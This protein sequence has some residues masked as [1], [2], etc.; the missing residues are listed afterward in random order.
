M[1]N[2][3]CASNSLLRINSYQNSITE[4]LLLSKG[5]ILPWV[6]QQV[7]IK[8]LQ[9]WCY[10]DPASPRVPGDCTYILVRTPSTAHGRAPWA[11]A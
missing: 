1:P 8:V 11:H 3:D 2:G 4:M 10:R 5:A 7:Q 9:A 6:L